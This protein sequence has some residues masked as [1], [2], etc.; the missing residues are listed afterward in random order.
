MVAPQNVVPSRPERQ[1]YA[2]GPV[3]GLPHTP[4]LC[5]HVVLR[6][7]L[8]IG[9]AEVRVV[10]PGLRDRG[11]NRDVRVTTGALPELREQLLPLTA[12]H[13][14]ELSAWPSTPDHAAG[15]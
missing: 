8:D 12:T 10:A 11:L 9:G 15:P 14:N 3:H 7:D 13:C 1:S 4:H 6:A 5:N 2:D